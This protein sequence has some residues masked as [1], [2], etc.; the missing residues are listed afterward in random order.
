MGFGIDA[1]QILSA[2]VAARNY[3]RQRG[4]PRCLLVLRDEVKA[5]FSEFPQSDADAEAVVIGDIGDTWSYALLDRIFRV[6]MNGAELVALH[7]NRY[8]QANG[9][10]K[11]DIGAFVAGLEYATGRTATIIGKPRREFFD[12]ALLQIGVS[13]SDTAMIGD[14]IRERCEGRAGPGN[15]RCAGAHREVPRGTCGA[16]GN[17]AG[18]A[19]GVLRRPAAALTGT[20]R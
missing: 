20:I 6:L 12:A 16:L 7:R 4:S 1:Q 15:L 10:L 9:G 13:A 5:D 11:L 2:P 8:W 19:A 14:D 3:L 18:P 17:H